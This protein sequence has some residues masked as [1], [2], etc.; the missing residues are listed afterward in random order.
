M[1]WRKLQ[2]L[3]K[4]CLWRKNRIISISQIETGNRTWRKIKLS[5]AHLIN[6]LKVRKWR[7]GREKIA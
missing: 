6:P 4:S 7:K 2:T 5:K 3:I 1:F